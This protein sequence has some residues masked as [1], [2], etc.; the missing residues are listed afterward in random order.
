MIR[1]NGCKRKMAMM[2]SF[3][4]CLLSWT[5]AGAQTQSSN[6]IPGVTPEGAVYFL[7]KTALRISVLV[8]KTTYE[9]GDF[10]PYAQRYLRM[11]N[12]S[13]EPKTS[14]RIADIT[15][16]PCPVPD[17]TKAYAV[18][19]DAR[20]VASR[21]TLSNDGRLLALNMDDAKDAEVPA[22]FVPA[23]RPEEVNPRQFLSEE[24]LSCGSTAKMAE[25]TAHE[26]Y[27]LRE[28]RTVL[29]KGQAD[30]MPQ[31]GRQMELMMNELNRQDRA[32]TSLFLGVTRCDTTEHVLWVVPSALSLPSSTR[33]VLFRLSQVKG[34]V[35][36]DDL[37]GAPFYYS[38][39]D[40]SQLPASDENA[41]KKAGKS[42][43]GIYVNIPGRLR[44]TLYEGIKPILTEEH[45]APQFGQTML[46]SGNLFNKRY[47][48][49]LLLHPLSGAL[50]H[51]DADQ[52]K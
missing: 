18:K 19:F 44:I 14:F 35:E 29:I 4:V 40:I 39:E 26:I 36:A 51:L 33:Q 10:A 20:T 6:Y 12:V 50:L 31:D 5:P 3:V 46:L 23:P 42:A 48:T 37:S 17:S 27:D 32:L 34:L 11:A 1:K 2:L 38:I 15:V 43:D 21:M 28:N 16:T 8:E 47:T 45:P 41:K 25:T 24:I 7:P 49:R 52:P 30:F 13:Q 22:F 9:P